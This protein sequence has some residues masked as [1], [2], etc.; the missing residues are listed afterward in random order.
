[1]SVN[2]L[3]TLATMD[4]PLGLVRRLVY[5]GVA[6]IDEPAHR[7]PEAALSALPAQCYRNVTALP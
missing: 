1:M 4:D 2:P 7:L 5:H 3:N 6:A